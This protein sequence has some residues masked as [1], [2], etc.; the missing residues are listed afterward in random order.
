MKIVSAC[1]AWINC[2]YDGKSVTCPKVAVLVQQG[3]AIPVCPEVLGWL[4]IPRE[5]A[6]KI[7]EKVF[8][9]S[10]KDLT[11]AFIVW[12]QKALQIAKENKC[13]EAILKFRSPS[14]GVG[15]IYDGNFTHTLVDGDWIFTEL[16]KNNWIHVITEKDL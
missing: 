7:G 15:K 5:I 10:G 16:L 12:A 9:V 14:C 3:K 13:T 6:E 2:T 1:L 11:H 4:S 8:T